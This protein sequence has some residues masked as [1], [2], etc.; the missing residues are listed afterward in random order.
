MYVWSALIHIIIA[1][2]WIGG[3]LFMV[4]ILVPATRN[5]LASQRGLLFTELGTRFSRMSWLLFPILFI[6]GIT[7]LLGR[8]YSIQ[9]LLSMSFWK[10]MYGTTLLNKLTVFSLMLI[11]TAIHD[12]WLGPKAATLMD[13]KP[14][15]DLTKT[16]RKASSWGGRINLVL[17]LVILYFA[18]SLVRW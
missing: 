1:C 4:A 16:Y 18:V 6:T 15:S 2:F 10:S 17:G 14:D 13:S 11:V 5:K 9:D 12:F 8:G 3:M 7:A